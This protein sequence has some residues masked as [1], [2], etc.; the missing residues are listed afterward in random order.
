MNG[1]KTTPL[2]IALETFL[3]RAFI[4]RYFQE[5]DLMTHP[6]QVMH[7][8]NEMLSRMCLPHLPGLLYSG[9]LL[10]VNMLVA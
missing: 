2:K 4:I 10:A 6:V 1:E 5:S 8:S 3:E 9:S 7:F